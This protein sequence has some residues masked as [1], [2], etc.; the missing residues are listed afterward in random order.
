M[1]GRFVFRTDCLDCGESSRKSAD[2]GISCGDDV[3]FIAECEECGCFSFIQIN[4]L[5]FLELFGGHNER[6]Q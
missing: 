5:D 4:Y 1:N 3:I 2:C 6:H